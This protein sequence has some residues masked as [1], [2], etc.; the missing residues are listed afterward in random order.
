MKF[1]YASIILLTAFLINNICAME[2]TEVSDL[3]A[4]ETQFEK[5]LISAF[6]DSVK[7]I[8]PFDE[9]IH[10]LRENYIAPDFINHDEPV[11]SK[12]YAQLANSYQKLYGFDQSIKIIN[13]VKATQ[14]AAT[15]DMFKIVSVNDLKILAAHKAAEL[16]NRE[17]LHYWKTIRRHFYTFTSLIGTG[18]FG[19]FVKH[20]F[21]TSTKN[22]SYI[23]PGIA[24]A[25]GFIWLTKTSFF[26][27]AS[28]WSQYKTTKELRTFYDEKIKSSI[29]A[30][31]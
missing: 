3:S 18:Y 11:D 2:I 25:C 1:N 15:L 24:A 30:L 14:D 7:K 17:S 27:G 6:D 19:N 9:A 8:E 28:H 29:D 23:V 21:Q 26:S 16:E 22:N 31:D 10:F 20:H 13:K 5:E 4:E 12:L